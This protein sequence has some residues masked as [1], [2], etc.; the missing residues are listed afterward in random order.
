MPTLQFKGKNI[1]WNH[2]LSVPYHTL[3]EVP[4][5]HYQP[6]QG[7]GNLII[8]GDN[9]LALKAL[10]P[11]YSGK[12]KCI[13]IDPP[14][15]TGKGSGVWVYND[16]VNSPMIKEWLGKVVDE[17]DLTKSDKWLCMMT[18]RVKLLKELLHSEGLIFVSIDEYEIHN[19]KT[20]FNEIF[21]EENRLTTLIWDLG[22]GTSA[23]HFT[24]SHEYILCY[25]NDRRMVP[26][27]SGGEGIIDERAVK[28]VSVKN[29]NKPYCFKR[30]TKWEAP[31]GME[32]S[33]T[34]GGDES[35]T[36]LEGSMVCENQ[37]LKYDVVI[38]AGYTQKDQMDSFFSGYETFD[39]KGQKVIEFYFREN[40]KIYSRKD[41]SVINPPS[42]IRNL[43]STKTGTAEL[44]RLFKNE[45]FD[46][47]KSTLLLKYILK[48]CTS[49]NDII[50]DSF[51][52][53]GT[54]MN[55]VAEL[56]KD[57]GSNRKSILIQMTEATETEPNKNI[58]KDITRERNKKSQRNIFAAL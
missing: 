20:L 3:D 18:P 56:N 5:L 14:Y 10:L 16:E 43:A 30:G 29:R 13:Y 32:L 39:S 38:E 51:A 7:D 28:K 53:S 25:A 41:R 50:L 33:G 4:E 27:F 46:F 11:Q 42:V 44:K 35:M 12:V 26:N 1:I 34:W 47:P 45:V 19:C 22:T 2:H 57:D 40:G 52:G 54:T 31:E 48:L 21:G 6:E 9:L 49:E 24:R 37:S 36:L 17:S 15:N 58:C 23:G 55:A 8:E